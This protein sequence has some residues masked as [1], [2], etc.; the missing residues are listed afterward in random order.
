[1]TD[2]SGSITLPALP[3]GNNVLQVLKPVTYTDPVTQEPRTDKPGIEID[4]ATPAAH[5][6]LN[7]KVE[8]QVFPLPDCKCTPWCAIGFGTYN[9][10]RTPI[11][12]AGGANGPKGAD[13]G[14]IT[15]AVTGPD[16]RSFPIIPGSGKHQSLA[17]PAAGTW[18]VTTTVCGVS[19]SCS[20]EV[21]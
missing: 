15:V 3:Y 13:C 6:T 11:Y 14:A 16:G 19:K 8:A 20:I 21:P 10:A 1:M 17:N 18:T 5:G 9:G 2:A 12:F 4:A 7:L